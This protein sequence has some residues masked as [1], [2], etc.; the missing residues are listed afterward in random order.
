MGCLNCPIPRRIFWL[1]LMLIFLL[2]LSGCEYLKFVKQK[3]DL[4]REFQNEPKMEILRELAPENCFAIYGQLAHYV[5]YKG[6]LL[7]VAVSDRF[8]RREVVA[9]LVLLNPALYYSVYVP[10][11]D[12]DL[13]VFADLNQDDFFAPRFGTMGLY[14]PIEF[15]AHTQGNLFQ[16]EKYHPQKTL[17]IFVH[18]VEGTPQDWK[19]LVDGL[20]QEQ[21]QSWFFYYPSGLP[22]NNLGNMLARSIMLLAQTPGYDIKN[23]IIVAHSMGGLVAHLSDRTQAVQ[24]IFHDAAVLHISYGSTAILLTQKGLPY[25][26]RAC[27]RDDEQAKAF[28]GIVRHLNFKKVALLSDSSLYGRG[29]AEAIASLLRDLMIETTSTGSLLPDCRKSGKPYRI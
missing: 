18:G 14:R 7:I 22:L 13:Y 21:F 8:Q 10:E 12:Y 29:L 27:P 3:S 24:G 26:F 25:F 5:D 23:L 9:K 2:P 15:M 6:A 20:E 1:I 16:L 19:Y 4:R 11:S 28:V 17:V